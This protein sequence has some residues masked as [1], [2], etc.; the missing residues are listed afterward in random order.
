MKIKVIH[1]PTK[2]EFKD[3]QVLTINL[4]KQQVTISETDDLS[5]PFDPNK[6]IYNLSDL[7]IEINNQN[8]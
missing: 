1:K 6:L 2:K 5:R 8:D 4:M 7:I 3:I